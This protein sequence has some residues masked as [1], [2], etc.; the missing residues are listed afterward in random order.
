MEDSIGALEPGKS[1][2][3]IGVEGDPLKDIEALKRVKT[4]ILQGRQAL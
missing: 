2:D 4:V 3:L 1:A